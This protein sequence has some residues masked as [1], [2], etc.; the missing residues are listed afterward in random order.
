MAFTSTILVAATR[1]DLD[2]GQQEVRGDR[3]VMPMP[4]FA[5][6]WQLASQ[7]SKWEQRVTRPGQ[8]N[9]IWGGN[10]TEDTH[11]LRLGDATQQCYAG[12]CGTQMKETGELWGGLWFRH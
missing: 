6:P 11:V 4:S 3:P 5:V 8:H 7:P 1:C 9:P 10:L 2:Q 12:Q